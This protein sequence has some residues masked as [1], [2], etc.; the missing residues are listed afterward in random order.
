M[1]EKVADFSVQFCIN[2]PPGALSID[3]G[4]PQ[5]EDLVFH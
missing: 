4:R 5:I 1:C 3:G 2:R